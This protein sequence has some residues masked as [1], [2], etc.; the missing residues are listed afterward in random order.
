MSHITTYPYCIPIILPGCPQLLQLIQQCVESIAP[1]SGHCVWWP[2]LSCL[3][4]CA[5]TSHG[6]QPSVRAAVT[7]SL[8]CV[9][10][11]ADA[12][13]C[14]LTCCRLPGSSLHS[15]IHIAHLL[16][17]NFFLI[18]EIACAPQQMILNVGEQCN[19]CCSC[20]MGWSQSD[21]HVYFT[22]DCWRQLQSDHKALIFDLKWSCCQIM[23]F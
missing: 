17:I 8:S 18:Q 3:L 9:T 10:S 21:T 19:L 15:V 12:A 7:P 20:D 5:A 14:Q 6:T 13:L 22:V 16:Q 2:L 1:L 11:A 23:I 4:E